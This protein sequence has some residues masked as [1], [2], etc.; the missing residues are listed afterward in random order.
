MH[1]K[2]KTGICS[3]EIGVGPL[4]WAFSGYFGP[5]LSGQHYTAAMALD[6]KTQAWHAVVVV[7][8]GSSS[9]RCSW[10]VTSWCMTASPAHVWTMSR[11]HFWPLLNTEDPMS[12]CSGTVNGKTASSCLSLFQNREG[13][14]WFRRQF[15]WML[16]SSS[17]Q[18]CPLTSHRS[19]HTLISATTEQTT[20]WFV[21]CTF[22]VH[23]EEVMSKVK[24]CR[25]TVSP[26]TGPGHDCDQTAAVS[27]PGEEGEHG[28]H[29]QQANGGSTR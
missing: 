29:A 10:C 25:L 23:T 15:A 4:M 8:V 2:T 20:T 19:C 13:I 6:C 21:H 17:P 9:D 18:G 27:S 1:K 26:T 14:L 28:S 5:Q 24:G 11:N 3:F 16:C 12:P 7:V 22:C